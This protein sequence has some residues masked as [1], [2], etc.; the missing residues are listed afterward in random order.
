MD[1]TSTVRTDAIPA[2]A[3]VIAPGAIASSPYLWAALSSAEQIRGFLDRH[4]AVAV[5]AAIVAWVVAGFS[6]ESLGSYVEVHWIDRARS[7]HKELLETWWRYLRIAWNKEPIG[8]HYVRRLLVTFK[9]E[10]NMF[11][12]TLATIPGVLALSFMHGIS[13]LATAFTIIGL[14]FAASLAFKAAKDSAQVLADVRTKLLLGVG[15]PP[16]DDKG[17]PRPAAAG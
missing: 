14:L 15:E 6:V 3:T 2:I 7:D 8:Q 12:A 10:L 16:F 17:N 11:V 13:E 5:A 1:P 4:E 9:F